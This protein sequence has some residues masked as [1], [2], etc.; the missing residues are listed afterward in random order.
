MYLVFSIF[1][2]SLKAKEYANA[3]VFRVRSA[4]QTSVVKTSQT[5]T[6]SP[7]KSRGPD[8]VDSAPRNYNSMTPT[9]ER[10]AL[11]SKMNQTKTAADNTAIVI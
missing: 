1:I 6:N 8:N 9:S 4:S 10:K 3:T 5:K 7:S 2:F 11:E